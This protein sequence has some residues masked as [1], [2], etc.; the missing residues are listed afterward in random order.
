MAIEVA[1][2]SLLNEVLGMKPTARVERLREDYLK[3]YWVASIGREQAE[4]KSLKETEGEPMVL[5]RAKAFSKICREM[6]IE[7]FEDEMIVG[8]F[9][10]EPHGCALP[11]KTDPK[12]DEKLDILISR[13]RNPVTFTDEQKQILAEGIMPYW[14][15]DGRHLLRWTNKLYDNPPLPEIRELMYFDGSERPNGI[16]NTSRQKAGHVGHTISNSQKV[17]DKGFLGIKQDAVNRL[18]RLD[19]SDPEELKKAPFLNGVIIAMEAAAEVGGRFAGRARELAEAE[20]DPKRKEE[21]LAIAKV[22]D[23]VPANPAKTFHEALQTMWFVH[24]INWWETRATAA[25]FFSG[26]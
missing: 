2:K 25:I 20:S 24:I 8:W 7:I 5:R 22:C 11:V 12:L 10:Y 14:R 23:R 18:A 21:L 9:D 1:E 6:P 16:I 19:R 3:P 17:F 15:G 4:V 13:E 26:H